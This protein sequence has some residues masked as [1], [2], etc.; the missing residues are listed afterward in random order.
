MLHSMLNIEKRLKG[1][2]KNFLCQQL[3]DPLD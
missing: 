1:V 2:S 3:T